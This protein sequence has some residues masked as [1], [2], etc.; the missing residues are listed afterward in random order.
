MSQNMTLSMTPYTQAGNFVCSQYDV[1]RECQITL[2]DEN[3]SYTI[4]TGATVTIQATKPSGFGFSVECTWSGSTVTFATTET[5][6]SEF[7]RFP[8]ELRITQGD[9]ILGTTNFYFKVERSPHPEGTVDG[10]SETAQALTLRV[11]ALEE[12]MA[13]V[14]SDITDVKSDIGDLDE[15][16]TEDKSSLVDAINEAR[17]S[18]GGGLTADIKTALLQIAQK[19]AYIDEDGQDYYDDLYDALYA[20]TAITLN[21]NS[22]SMQSIGATSQLTATTTPAGGNVT[23]SS[24]N[25]SVATVST[26][27]LVTSVAYGS[28]TITATAG[29]V[30]ATCSVVVAQATCTG[31]TATYTQ[32][33]TVYDTATLDS[34]KSDLVVTASWSDSTT[35]T[36]S[37]NDYTL[38]GT[39]EVGTSN[40]TVSYGGQTDTF[41]VTV[42]HDMTYTET[43][44][45][46]LVPDTD[47]SYVSGTIDKT[48][49]AVTEDSSSSYR[50]TEF[51]AIPE[52]TTSMSY[53]IST[54]DNNTAIIYYDTEQAFVG[55]GYGNASYSGNGTYGDA[56]TDTNGDMWHAVPATAKYLKIQWRPDRNT[57][58]E[59]MFKHN[60][61]LDETVTPIVG[62]VYYYTYTGS[63]TSANSDDYLPC[64]GMA[65]AHARCVYRR[66]YTLYDNDKISVQT[67]AVTN[68]IGNNV[69]IPSTA[70]FIKFGNTTNASTGN[71]GVVSRNGIGLIMFSDDS[72]TSW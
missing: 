52:G 38:S 18:G 60:I 61:K 28:A 65:Y 53:D 35:T 27:G 11:D 41:D 67:Q 37:A 39:L 50:V 13:T 12:Q 55:N 32:S 62:T 31:I 69:S 17:G 43:I 4:P 70:S 16:E 58:S 44:L 64:A 21:T 24:S 48:T 9:T 30:S 22:I 6:T 71:S 8:A 3:G 26:T 68:N 14:Q 63:N 25:T 23:W 45:A 47:F 29:S 72:L 36:L 42:S 56:Y 7:G 5:M 40:I 66:G 33:G 34:L 57:F 49:G 51:I 19:V 2:Q 59:L 15:L 54:W 46:T 10:D 1:G 20:I